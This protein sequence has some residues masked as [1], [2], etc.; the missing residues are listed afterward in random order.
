MERIL[1]LFS[2]FVKES[3]FKTAKD[4]VDFVNRFDLR[5][6]LETK[7]HT[8]DEKGIDN[9][10][11][12]VSTVILKYINEN[13]EFM[14]EEGK[15]FFDELN[16]Y[17]KHEF[18]S[19]VCKKIFDDVTLGLVAQLGEMNCEGAGK[20]SYDENKQQIVFVNESFNNN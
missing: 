17:E 19:L 6:N 5:L 20:I 7:E 2:A 18:S 13:A 3:I 1:E 10:M 4:Y 12:S 11:E 14:S 16:D 8:I 15:D 9:C